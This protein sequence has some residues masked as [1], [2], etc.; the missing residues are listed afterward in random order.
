MREGKY[1]SIIISEYEAGCRSAR[2]MGKKIG[3]S[4][5]YITKRCKTLGLK[6]PTRYEVNSERSKDALSKIPQSV[7]D[8]ADESGFSVIGRIDKEHYVLRCL[9]CGEHKSRVFDKKY[10]IKCD[11]CEKKKRDEVFFKNAKQL[12]IVFPSIKAEEINAIRRAERR[13]CC[14]C[15]K[16]FTE[17]DWLEYADPSKK[18]GRFHTCCSPACMRVRDESRRNKVGTIPWQMVMKHYGTDRCYLCGGKVD[19]NDY[20]RTDSGAFVAGAMYPSTDHVVAIANGGDGSI[21]NSRLAHMKCNSL[22]SDTP[23]EVYMEVRA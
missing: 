2:A 6:M 12:E 5:S 16:E 19:L 9:S 15:G 17:K 4:Q 20:R 14:V 21:E 23:L 8:W 18:L 1:D 10:G 7:H 11:A 3:A 22:K 13:V